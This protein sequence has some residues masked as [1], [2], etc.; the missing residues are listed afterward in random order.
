MTKA[1]PQ[2]RHH[3]E[4]EAR[5]LRSEAH[6]AYLDGRTKRARALNKQ[7]DEMDRQARALPVAS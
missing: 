3:L 5:R 7:A 6:Y 2:S 4:D 1:I